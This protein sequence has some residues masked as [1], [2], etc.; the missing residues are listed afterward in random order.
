[1]RK[2]CSTSRIV[3]ST[4]RIVDLY[5]QANNTES[6]ANIL[7]FFEVESI[8]YANFHSQTPSLPRPALPRM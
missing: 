3:C 7:L 6:T 1:M 5:N 8:F 4:S 2:F